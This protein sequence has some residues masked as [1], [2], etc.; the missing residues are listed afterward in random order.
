M[1]YRILFLLALLL[2]VHWQP[3]AAQGDVDTPIS[4]ENVIQLHSIARLNF[5]DMQQSGDFVDS[6]GFVMDGA[7]RRLAFASRD[8]RLF[9]WDYQQGFLGGR[10]FLEADDGLPATVVYTNFNPIGDILL[11]LQSGGAHYT[12]AYYRVGGA[13]GDKEQQIPPIAQRAFPSGIMLFTVWENDTIPHRI[14]WLETLDELGK[15][16]FES[17][18]S[19]YEPNQEAVPSTPVPSALHADPTAFTRIGRVPLPFAVTSSQDGLVKLWNLETGKVISQAKVDG[20]PV[21]GQ[22]NTSGSHLAWRDPDSNALHLLDFATGKDEVVAPLYGEYI[23]FMF[24]TLN[25]DVI[26]GVNL[27]LQPNVVAWDTATGKRYD[28]GKYRQC[29][30]VPDMAR[31]SKDGTT[32]V[33]GCDTGLDIW[34]IQG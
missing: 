3:V 8:S 26:I 6:G 25:A 4:R 21:F 1:R 19:L 31:L 28:L 5:A 13:F 33:I 9:V 18:P 23:Q 11:A 2:V 15:S 17:F 24:L 32:L 16:Y 34:R 27:D 14:T 22:I 10:Y 30:R 29:S 7:G 20:L 12:L